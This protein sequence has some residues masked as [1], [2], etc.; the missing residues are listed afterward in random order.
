VFAKKLNISKRR[1][2]NYLKEASGPN[3]K[4]LKIKHGEYKKKSPA[5]LQN[6]QYEVPMDS[7]EY[8][9]END[10]HEVEAFK[11]LELSVNADNEDAQHDIIQG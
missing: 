11:N 9:V 3:G 4:I 6:V 5:I 2:D 1:M 10:D 7:N 8:S